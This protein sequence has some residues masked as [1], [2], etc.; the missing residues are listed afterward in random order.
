MMHE[1]YG[2]EDGTGIRLH[3]NR[4]QL[5]EYLAVDRSTLSRE[6]RRMEQD[7]LLRLG[8]SY[9]YYLL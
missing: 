4:T 9:T 2:E 5:A 7:G 3:M 1:R 6:L 8:D